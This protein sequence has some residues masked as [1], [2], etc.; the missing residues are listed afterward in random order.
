MLNKNYCDWN[1]EILSSAKIAMDIDKIVS[2]RTK[3]Q[4]SD[5]LRINTN[6]HNVSIQM[7][8]IIQF[9]AWYSYKKT[10]SYHLLQRIVFY[11]CRIVFYPRICFKSNS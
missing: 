8:F 1:L 7:E 6:T 5:N 9:K 2:Y 3:W 4:F 10:T 11:P